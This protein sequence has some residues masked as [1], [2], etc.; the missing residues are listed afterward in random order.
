MRPTAA[1]WTTDPLLHNAFGAVAHDTDSYITIVDPT[2]EKP[3]RIRTTAVTIH[4]D[5]DFAAHCRDSALDWYAACVIFWSHLV[6]FDS[7]L[8]L[9]ISI[10]A[11]T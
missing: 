5:T 7:F 2:L 8:V 6:N 10:G 1:D 3:G 11:T 9:V 4:P